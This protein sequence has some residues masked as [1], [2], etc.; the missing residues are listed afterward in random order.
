MMR[1]DEKNVF[2]CFDVCDRSFFND[3]TCDVFKIL[4]KSSFKGN[5]WSIERRCGSDS[6]WFCVVGIGVCLYHKLFDTCHWGITGHSGSN[7]ECGLCIVF[8]IFNKFVILW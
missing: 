8:L 7:I 6:D 2:D 4:Y 1:K 3:F 5:L